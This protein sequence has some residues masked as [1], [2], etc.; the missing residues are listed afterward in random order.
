MSREQQFDSGSVLSRARPVLTFATGMGHEV[1][2]SVAQHLDAPGLPPLRA[3]ESPSAALRAQLPVIPRI[4]RKTML[5]DHL[6]FG[7]IARGA[8]AVKRTG[9][10]TMLFTALG[11]ATLGAIFFFG[12]RT[13]RVSDVGEARTFDATAIEPILARS[14]PTTRLEQTLPAAQVQRPAT[15]AVAPSVRSSPPPA[16]TVFAAAHAARGRTSGAVLARR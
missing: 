16:H 11:V 3:P 13:V 14:T 10:G 5:D 8:T 2:P 9:P 6:V 1:P 7:P 12:V 15:A 4:V